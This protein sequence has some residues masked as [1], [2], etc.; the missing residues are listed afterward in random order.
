[1]QKFEPPFGLFKGEQ[2][3]LAAIMFTDMVGYS[4]MTQKNE[5]LALE[6]L[7]EHRRIL[8]PLFTRHEGMEIKTIGDAFLV[9]FES[10]L[11]AVSCAIDMQ[12]TL[13]EYNAAFPETVK[14][15]IRI[16]IHL[17]DVVHRGG[18]VYGDGVNIAARIEPLAEPGGICVTEDVYRQVQNKLDVPMMRLGQGDLKHIDI[19][20]GIYKVGK[21]GEVQG[22][23]L[24][25]QIKFFFVR[26]SRPRTLLF[27][28]VLLITGLSVGIP[29]LWQAISLKPPVQV[30]VADF[31]NETG[32]KRLEALAG[33]L[34]TPLEQSPQLNVMTRARMYE[35][36][37]SLGKGRSARV[38][39][40]LARQICKETNT[41]VL[42]MGFIRRFD[43]VYIIDLK[44]LEPFK[45][46]YLLTLEAEGDGLKEVPQLI[47]QLAA[48]LRSNLEGQVPGL[49]DA[50]RNT[51]R[52]LK[53]EVK[54]ALRDSLNAAP[55]PQ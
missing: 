7:E 16:G 13:A 51:A 4:M 21:A 32:N 17:G 36:L 37:Q 40:S 34:I 6:L 2:R 44:V 39:E 33:Q 48:D 26:P 3:K 52:L 50:A 41:H 29:M 53:R 24:L 46:E 43:T 30:V 55:L 35:V 1:M 42:V 27:Q 20:V 18:D 45:E 15:E 11:D 54:Q 5:K 38:S 47:N 14:I 9:S 8:R 31:V 19:P 28:L 12:K 25:Q 10:A 49:R 22:V 23:P